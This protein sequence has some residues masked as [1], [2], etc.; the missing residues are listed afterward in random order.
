LGNNPRRF[1]CILKKKCKRKSNVGQAYWAVAS[2]VVTPIVNERL[3][4]AM[5]SYEASLSSGG[6]SQ[7]LDFPR[8]LLMM[9]TVAAV[10]DKKPH[11]LALGQKISA[12]LFKEVSDPEMRRKVEFYVAN[13]HREGE[14]P[15]KEDELPQTP[16]EFQK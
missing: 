15:P 2:N 4:L 9:N 3:A 11:R 1:L 5:K 16:E 13:G 12:E 8:S 7:R 14:N 6:T 10:P